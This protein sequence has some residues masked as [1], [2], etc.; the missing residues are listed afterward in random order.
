VSA[1]SSLD[2]PAASVS[3]AGVTVELATD[4]AAWNAFVAGEPE[5]ALAHRWEWGTVIQETYGHRTHRFVAR[6][7]RG[8]AGILALVEVRSRLFGA[9]LS[10]MPYLDDGGILAQNALACSGLLNAA[11]ALAARLRIRTIELRQRHRP[12][13]D[14]PTHGD[15]A[16]LILDLT[17]GAG[18][19][20]ASPEARVE[21]LWKAIGSKPRN[22]VRKAEK[23]GLVATREGPAGVR[24]FYRVWRVNMR[25]LGSPAHAER[26][27]E[28]VAAHFAAETSI[29]LVRQGSQVIGGLMAI[30]HGSTV[31]VPWASSDRRFFDRCPN[32]LLYWATL[33]DAAARGLLR[34]DFGRSAVGSGTYDFKSQWGATP[35]PLYWQ[36]LDPLVGAIPLLPPG[37]MPRPAPTPP[38]DSKRELGERV[39]R[40][41]PVPVATWLGARLRGGITL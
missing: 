34:F 17:A 27:F 15:R 2:P 23:A 5:A 12:R 35:L 14:L 6:G 37:A 8:I 29:T 33:K 20:P 19:A 31:V 13:A 4:P 41:L 3:P 11:A 22:Q 36:D 26:W 38:P 21:A 9:R 25:D 1:H 30:E 40:R 32:N 7:P 18:P 39:W 16:T 10:S 24:D 28:R